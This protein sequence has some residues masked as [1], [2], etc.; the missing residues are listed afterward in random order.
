MYP[1]TPEALLAS[2]ARSGTEATQGWLQLMT[3]GASADVPSAVP[4]WL[5]GLQHN[6]A[7]FGAIQAEY[8]QKQAQLWSAL[9]GGK[10]EAIAHA[11]PGDRRFAAKAWDEN[12]YYDYL[13][14]S[15]LLASRYVE[16]LVEAADLDAQAK[17]RMRFA[18]R[19]WIDAMSPTNF[20]AT[21]PEALE[22]AVQ[23]RGESLTKG[24]AN[25]LED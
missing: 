20:A 21:N 6:V 11:E 9:L 2:L 1:A 5:A 13:K 4:P 15:Y 10:R 14:Q 8:A 18:A 24:L 12:P 19:Q 3:G 25:L 7:R 22:Q 23:S 16:E 17:E